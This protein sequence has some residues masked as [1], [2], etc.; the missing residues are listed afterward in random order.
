MATVTV[1][2]LALQGGF[3]EPLLAL[4]AATETLGATGYANLDFRLIEVRNIK[5][6][7]RCDG[8]IIPGGQSTSISLIAGRTNLLE[9]LREFV[10]VKR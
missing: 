9:A 2:V 3:T 7:W 4:A 1:G 5:Q 10:K 8:L 6:L